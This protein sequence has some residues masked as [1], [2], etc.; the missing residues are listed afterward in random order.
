MAVG[1]A[2]LVAVAVLSVAAPLFA[3]DALTM[4][5]AERLRPPS[6]VNWFGTDHLGRDV[7]ARTVYGARV[8]LIVGLTVAILSVSLGLLVGLLAGY[9]RRVDAVVMRLMDGLMS[10]PGILLAIALVALTRA[11]VTT[12]IAAITIPEIPRVVRL[13]RS[14][15]LS[16]REAPYVEAAISGGTPVPR[17][18]MRHILPNTVAPLIVQ[19]TYI[20]ASAI[21]IEAGLSFLGA[22]TPPEI[23]TW[24]NMI[25]QSRLFLSRAPWTIFCPGI[26]L[27]LV[28]LAVNLLGDG[29][30]DRLD[31]RLARRM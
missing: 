17:I 3:G 31:P 15:V 1:G 13:V 18:L 2:I 23:P 21:L 9:F 11:S 19:A 10:I 27:A 5:P 25:A 29:L 12:V 26:A 24:G 22:G 14:V 20:C 8:S 28:V 16:V 30:R 4:K 7:F 6:G